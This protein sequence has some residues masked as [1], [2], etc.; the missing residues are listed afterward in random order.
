MLLFRLGAFGR[1]L[2]EVE[3]GET[4]QPVL[5]LDTPTTERDG[6]FF[7]QT[8]DD[9]VYDTIFTGGCEDDCCGDGDCA[10]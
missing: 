4:V 10:Y 9:V 3:L 6:C 8:A 2:L 5:A 7:S 1:T